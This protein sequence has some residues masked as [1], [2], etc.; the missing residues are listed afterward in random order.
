MVS[1]KLILK[2]QQRF[3]R[4]RYNVFTE[5]V[6]KIALSSSDNERMQRINSIE[7]YAY[8]ASKDLLS[9]KEEIKCN[10]TIKR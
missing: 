2:T 8:R 3:K 10:K 4:E 5:E 7:T 9:Q 1:N 6:N